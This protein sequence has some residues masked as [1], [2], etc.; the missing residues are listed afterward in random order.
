MLDGDTSSGHFKARVIIQDG[1][2]S[3]GHW[4]FYS[5]IIAELS[6]G[7]FLLRTRRLSGGSGH[8]GQLV[9]V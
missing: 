3:S 5:V 1:D 8:L 2:T 9:S 4:S 6:R 7:F